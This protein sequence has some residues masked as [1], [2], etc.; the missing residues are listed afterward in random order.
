MVLMVVY[1]ILNLKILLN[2]NLHQAVRI[3][4]N[5]GTADGYYI[6][7]ATPASSQKCLHVDVIKSVKYLILWSFQIRSIRY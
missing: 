7:T 2:M 3:Q 4:D 6:S 1:E 5:N